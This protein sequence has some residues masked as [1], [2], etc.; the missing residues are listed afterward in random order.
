MHITRNVY[1]I[2]GLAADERLFENLALPTTYKI[3]HVKWID[4]LKHEDLES[5]CHRLAAQIDTTA[6][7]VLVGMSFG[8]MVAVELNKFLKPQQTILISSIATRN[9]LSGFLK[10]VDLLHLHKLV[11]GFI[12]KNFYP[13][14]HWFF[15]AHTKAQKKL[16][17][18]FMEKAS[19]TLLVWSIDQVVGW[20]NEFIP[21]NIFIINGSADRVFPHKRTNANVLIKDGGH[22]MVHSKAAEISPVLATQL[23]KVKW[24]EAPVTN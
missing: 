9:G 11:P 8:G 14:A 3:H 1:F 21:K 22:M 5:Y 6:P 17:K 10:T 7:F 4:P 15:N 12:Y 18:S 13:A 24:Q 16:V 2:S 20:R 19:R 23:A